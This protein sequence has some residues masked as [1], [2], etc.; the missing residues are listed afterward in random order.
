MKERIEDLEMLN[1]KLK[2]DL[3]SL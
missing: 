2:Q 3:L 1:M